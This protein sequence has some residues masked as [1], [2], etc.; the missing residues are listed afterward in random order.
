MKIYSI[1]LS[2]EVQKSFSFFE[3][4]FHFFS[5]DFEFVLAVIAVAV[6]GSQTEGAGDGLVGV[7]GR[8]VTRKFL[9]TFV[10]GAT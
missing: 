1:K 6:K 9:G 7:S 8:D 10:L 2:K 4:S 3:K 5:V